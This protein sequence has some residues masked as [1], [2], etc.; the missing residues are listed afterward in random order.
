MV[1]I[2]WAIAYITTLA[3]IVVFKR[4]VLLGGLMLLGLSVLPAE[5]G[6]WITPSEWH[7]YVGMMIYYLPTILA[8]FV[9][10]VVL[11]TGLGLAISRIPYFSDRKR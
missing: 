7:D 2:M 4:R 9:A 5:Y 11:L 6:R 10:L 3:W 8:A 1:M